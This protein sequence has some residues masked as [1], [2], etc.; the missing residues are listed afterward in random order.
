MRNPSLVKEAKGKEEGSKH[1][2]FVSG[3][4]LLDCCPLRYHTTGLP[5]TQ[6]PAV[7]MG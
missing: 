2:R 7:S 5:I 1:K 3:Y 6:N 4:S